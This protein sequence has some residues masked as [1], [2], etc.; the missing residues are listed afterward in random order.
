MYKN[1]PAKVSPYFIVL[2]QEWFI[3][4]FENISRFLKADSLSCEGGGGAAKTNK[5]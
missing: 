2:L 1:Q 3:W 5:M 4:N